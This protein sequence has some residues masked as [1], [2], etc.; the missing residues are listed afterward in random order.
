M[1]GK[2]IQSIVNFSFRKFAYNKVAYYAGNNSNRNGVRDTN[3]SRCRCDGNQSH[4]STDGSSHGRKFMSHDFIKK[5]PSHCSGSGS[6]SGGT[7][8][9][10][11]KTSSS[12]GR[13]CIETKP[14]KPQ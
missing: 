1:T 9:L 14:S 13:S 10:C 12:N 8:C 3:E 6:N 2:N 7:Q 11:G 4:N 5:Y